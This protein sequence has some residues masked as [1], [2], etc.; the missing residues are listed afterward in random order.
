MRTTIDAVEIPVSRNCEM[1]LC[2]QCEQRY[3]RLRLN[4]SVSQ[5][6]R[7]LHRLWGTCNNRTMDP[8]RAFQ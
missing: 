6:E 7:V 5:R 1:T 3:E 2:I 8:T 4:T